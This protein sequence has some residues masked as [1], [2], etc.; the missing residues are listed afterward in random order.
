MH[1]LPCPAPALPLALAEPAKGESGNKHLRLCDR[2]VRHE[3]GRAG[4]DWVVLVVGRG[5][6]EE[7]VL[8][9]PGSRGE[10]A[11]RDMREV[12]CRGERAGW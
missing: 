11:G 5:T 7:L 9:R 2:Q 4:K 1:R 10:W 12:G 6:G 8:G 3:V